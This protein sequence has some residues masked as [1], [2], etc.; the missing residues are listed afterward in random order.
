MNARRRIGLYGGSFDPVHSGHLEVAR[1]VS[2]LFDIDLLLFIPAEVAPHKVGRK[3]TASIHRHT[4]L[5]LATQDDRSILVSTYELNGPER[6]YTV[7]T[8]KHFLQVFLNDEVFFLMG[9]D[10]WEEIHTWRDWELL[11]SLT[12]HIVVTRPGYEIDVQRLGPAIVERVVDLRGSDRVEVAP[13]PRIFLTDVVQR[14]ISATEI[15]NAVAS[16]NPDQLAKLVP[17]TVAEYISK[18]RLYRNFNETEFYS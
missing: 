6:R 14:D 10:S 3:V 4:M 8:L 16:E 11:L 1:K 13:E 17:Q 9:A 5:A 18:Y 15:R 2:E 7:D 12:N